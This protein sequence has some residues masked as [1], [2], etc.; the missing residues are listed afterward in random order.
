MKHQV[1]PGHLHTVVDLGASLA[2][3][4][5]RGNV[6]RL[7]RRTGSDVAEPVLRALEHVGRLH[8]ASDHE[9]RV[10]RAVVPVEEVVNVPQRG[11]VQVLHVPDGRVTVRVTFGIGDFQ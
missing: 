6:D 7:P 9:H 3:A 11:A 8:V 10:V 2:L 4:L 5:G 1:H